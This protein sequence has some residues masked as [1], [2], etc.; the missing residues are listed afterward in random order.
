MS[1]NRESWGE[2]ER[3]ERERVENLKLYVNICRRREVYC[4]SQNL[5]SRHNSITTKD[6]SVNFDEFVQSPKLLSFTRFKVLYIIAFHF[7]LQSY[8]LV[9]SCTILLYNRLGLIQ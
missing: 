7:Y 4:R 8:P 6:L 2:R 3:G 5:H 1:N 9:Q